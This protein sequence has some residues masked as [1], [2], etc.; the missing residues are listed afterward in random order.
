MIFTCNRFQFL[1]N[2]LQIVT[3]NYGINRLARFEEQIV[4]KIQIICR[5]SCKLWFI[6]VSSCTV[7]KA[8]CK[9]KYYGSI[10]I[11]LNAKHT[12]PTSNCETTVELFWLFILEK[13]ILKIW[14][15]L[16]FL[17]VKRR[18]F[19]AFKSVILEVLSFSA[20]W[21]VFS[22]Y[23]FLRWW[24]LLIS[25]FLQFSKILGWWM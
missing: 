21:Y 4:E 7:Y 24:L 11:V 25:T 10:T 6:W 20:F 16:S 1:D 15:L 19:A 12:L 18:H 14:N 22:N 17:Y 9:Q 23:S 2:V 3:R 13:L 8:R 5:K